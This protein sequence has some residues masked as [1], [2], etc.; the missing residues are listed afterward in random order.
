MC[1]SNLGLY[2]FHSSG[3]PRK[4]RNLDLVERGTQAAPCAWPWIERRTGTSTGVPGWR[5]APNWPPT[6]AATSDSAMTA[7]LCYRSRFL[8]PQPNRSGVHAPYS[9]MGSMGSLLR[10]NPIT[11]TQVKKKKINLVRPIQ[12]SLINAMQLLLYLGP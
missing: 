10:T 6:P 1:R 2:R 4:C 11:T 5:G 9:L 12:F 3:A 7:S 8:I